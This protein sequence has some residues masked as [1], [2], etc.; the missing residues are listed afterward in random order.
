MNRKALEA[1][2]PTLFNDIV[3]VRTGSEDPKEVRT[4]KQT[5][6]TLTDVLRQ[7]LTANKVSATDG[8]LG[9]LVSAVND[10]MGEPEPE[11]E[12]KAPEP[13]SATGTSG[14]PPAPP[15]PE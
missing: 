6:P 9:E 11:T 14:P 15:A 12:E 5:E 8:L 13:V 7:V 10:F 3:H 1:K 2:Y 4:A